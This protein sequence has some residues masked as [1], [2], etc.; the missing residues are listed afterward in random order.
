MNRKKKIIAVIIV[1]IVGTI[2]FWKRDWLKEKLGLSQ[3][4]ANDMRKTGNDTLPSGS[5]IIY[6][7]CKL[8]PFKIG[9]K[10]DPIKA[11]Q[12]KLNQKY[13]AGLKE[14]GYFGPKTE[15]ALVN[16]GYGKVLDVAKTKELI[17]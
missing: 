10:G 3:Q 12:Y 8:P 15:Q 2:I 14:D 7:E 4:T 11:I 1:A 6:H 17:N 16:A 13:H 5:G 9:C